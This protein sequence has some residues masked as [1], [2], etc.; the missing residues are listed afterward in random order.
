VEAVVSMKHLFITMPFIR[1]EMKTKDGRYVFKVLIY[2]G[3]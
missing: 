3:Y 1:S 2:E